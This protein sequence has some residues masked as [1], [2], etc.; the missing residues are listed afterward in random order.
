MMN[1]YKFLLHICYIN[2]NLNICSSSF[3]DATYA[4][5]TIFSYRSYVKGG[6]IRRPFKLL[7]QDIVVNVRPCL[8]CFPIF[9]VVFS[10]VS[11]CDLW[12]VKPQASFKGSCLV[13]SLSI[14]TIG[15][16]RG[17][18]SPHGIPT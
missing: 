14:G 9:I 5:F 2:I 11:P 13:V 6:L 8:S 10:I 16:I 17:N 7:T 18:T 4:P 15:T 12:I 3:L 1:S